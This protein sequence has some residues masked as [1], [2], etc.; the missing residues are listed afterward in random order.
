MAIP[1]PTGTDLQIGTD[2]NFNT[3]INTDDGTYRTSQH[4]EKGELPYGQT[5]YARVRHK[6]AE[7]GVSNW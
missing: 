4:F 7:T 5:L 3:I 6:S 2:S 1:T